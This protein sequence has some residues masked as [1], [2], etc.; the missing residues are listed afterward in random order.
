M[1]LVLLEQ[2]MNATEIYR[3]EVLNITVFDKGFVFAVKK[4]N[5][6]GSG[7]GGG[8]EESIDA[9]DADPD[10]IT[11]NGTTIAGYAS[12][13]ADNNKINNYG[14]WTDTSLT[15]ADNTIWGGTITVRTE[16]V[17]IMASAGY[18]ASGKAS[19][20]GVTSASANNNEISAYGIKSEGS[21]TINEMGTLVSDDRNDGEGTID[22]S[23]S[24]NVSL[25]N[26]RVQV[27][28]V[29]QKETK[30]SASIST[31]LTAAGI[32]AKTLTLGKVSNDVEIN[33]TANNNVVA[34]KNCERL[35][36]YKGL[37]LAYGVTKT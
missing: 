33:V 21:I 34:I 3:G 10:F 17:R 14:I 5:S 6:G 16:N 18:L 19:E 15:T 9:D 32:D 1:R 37:C 28:A 25:S 2:L 11:I 29:N 24:I 35:A 12:P 30:A 8:S 22:V 23:A 4:E 13:H 7:G 26:N 31:M 27:K 20:R 36:A